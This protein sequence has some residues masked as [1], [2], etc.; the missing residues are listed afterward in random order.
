MPHSPSSVF[1]EQIH[2]T[3]VPSLTKVGLP[4]DCRK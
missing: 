3:Q 4:M 2:A 1:Q